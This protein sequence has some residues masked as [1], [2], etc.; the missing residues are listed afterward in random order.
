MQC[1]LHV[2]S[3]FMFHYYK[4]NDAVSDDYKIPTLHLHYAHY[5]FL[6]VESDCAST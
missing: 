1:V 2:K 6:R 4:L 5:I 3:M